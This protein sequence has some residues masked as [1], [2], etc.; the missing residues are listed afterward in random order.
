MDELKPSPPGWHNDRRVSLD[1]VF[2][3]ILQI[4]AGGISILMVEGDAVKALKNCHRRYVLE[5]GN[6]R[7]GGN[8]KDLLE[9][10]EVRRLY[11][12]G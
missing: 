9:N 10:G 5:M 6:N 4:D 7:F 2:E 12:G 1:S 3:S 8:A 11:L